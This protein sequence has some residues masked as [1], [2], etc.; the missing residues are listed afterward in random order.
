ML[1]VAEENYIKAIH[2]LQVNGTRVSTNRIAD[3]QATRPSSVTDMLKKLTEKGHVEYI[4]YQGA[5]LTST[6]NSAALKIIRKHRLWEVFLLEKLD[7]TWDEV[8]EVAEQLEHIQSPKLI[9]QLDKLLGFP[10]VDPHGDPI[11]D[12]DG[13]LAAFETI[14]LNNMSV[15]SS[16]VIRKLADTSSQF[17]NYLDRKNIKLGLQITVLSRESF[18]HSITATIGDINHQLSQEVTT[19]LLIEKK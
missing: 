3:Y 11:P 17:L 18:D 5:R 1:T 12:S 4:P 8:H 15:G 19:K 6:G 10:R 13:K 2:H 16:G 7:F 14:S 9:D